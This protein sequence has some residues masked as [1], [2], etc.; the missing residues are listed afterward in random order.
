MNQRWDR[1]GEE[2]RERQGSCRSIKSYGDRGRKQ[3][4]WVVKKSGRESTAKSLGEV[5]EVL[6]HED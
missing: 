3:K 2:D 1:A 5:T 4:F 6:E